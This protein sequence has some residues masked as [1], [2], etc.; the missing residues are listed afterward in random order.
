[1]ERDARFVS[2]DQDQ[3]IQNRTHEHQRQ[4]REAVNQSVRESSQIYEIMLMQEIQSIQNRY[5]G[6][7]EDNERR[8]ARVIGSEARRAVRDQRSHMLQK[9]SSSSSSRRKRTN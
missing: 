6:R 5:E 9:T 8:V 2:F 4:A 1:M 3:A 7:L